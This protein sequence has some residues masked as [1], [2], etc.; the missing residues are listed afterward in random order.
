MSTAMNV[1]Q[2]PASFD[3]EA[4]AN[5][6]LNLEFVDLLVSRMEL[7]MELRFYQ[8]YGVPEHQVPDGD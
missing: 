7:E 3:D 4:R 8:R 1:T 5:N 2:Q 6:Q